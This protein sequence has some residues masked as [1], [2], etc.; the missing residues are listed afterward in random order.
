MLNFT[1]ERYI[2]SLNSAQISYEHWHRY[3]YASQ[4]V[5]NK[6]ILDIASGEGYGSNYLANSAK[7]V[8]GVD[9][10]EEA[11]AFARTNYKR[12][13][14]EFLIGS[15][16]KIPIDRN[17]VFDVIVSFETIEHVN[18]ESQ[19]K[20]L[21]ETIRLLK[22]D[23]LFIVSTPNKLKYTDNN[24]NYKNDYHI[25]EFYI[26]EFETFLGKY[27]SNIVLIGQKVGIGS[28]IWNM[29]SKKNKNIDF[30]LKYEDNKFIPVEETEDPLYVIAICSNSDLNMKDILYSNLIDISEMLK[31]EYDVMLQESHNRYVNLQEQYLGSVNNFE[32][33][34]KKLMEMS[35]WAATLKKQADE[36]SDWAKKLNREVVAKDEELM[37]M[38]D[39]ATT[40]KQEVDGKNSIINNLKNQIDAIY[41]SNIW[42]FGNKLKT[43]AYKT[44]VIYL[45]RI[46]IIIKRYGIKEL[47]KRIKNKFTY[48]FGI[49]RFIILNNKISIPVYIKSQSK[50]KMTE[51]PKKNGQINYNIDR[52][53]FNEENQELTLRGWAYIINKNKVKSTIKLL[54]VSH[55]Q[56][57]I[58]YT[59]P[60]KRSDV[61]LYFNN[62]NLDDSGF[63]IEIDLKGIE[64]GEYKVGILIQ[65]YSIF[66]Q[67]LQ[68]IK[69]DKSVSARFS[70]LKPI[71]NNYK[72]CLC[73]YEEFLSKRNM[74]FMNTSNY[75]ILFFSIIDWDTRYQRP[76]HIASGL[77]EMNHR[78][79]YISA[80]LREIGTYSFRKIKENIYEITLPYYK[81]N[82]IYSEEIKKDITR[83]Y[84]TMDSLFNDF[85][86]KESIAFVEFPMW[87]HIVK[88]IKEKYDVKVVFDLLDEFSG[89]SNVHKNIKNYEEKM[90]YL[91]DLCIVTSKKILNNINS[92]TDRYQIIPNATEFE[93]FN[94]L[95]VSKDKYLMVYDDRFSGRW[96]INW[97]DQDNCFISASFIVFR[98]D[99]IRKNYIS[100]IIQEDI[101]EK[102]KTGILYLVSNDENPLLLHSFKL[103][104]FKPGNN[105]SEKNNKPIEILSEEFNT[106][107]S[108]TV[109]KPE[110]RIINHDY[111]K[112]QIEIEFEMGYG[113]RDIINVKKPIIG[114][115]GAIA[116]WFDTDIIDYIAKTKPEWNIVLIGLTLGS[117]TD[118]LK[119]Y[120]N[121]F[122]LGEKPYEE[123]T[124]Y[125]YWFD[126]CLIPFKLC[127]LILSTNPVKFFEYLSSGK[128][129]VSSDLPELRPYQ[130]LFYMAKTKEQF[131][132]K[133]EMA[134]KEDDKEIIDRRIEFARNND[135]EHRIADILSYIQNIFPKVSI[136]IISYNN[137]EIT[138][139]CIDSILEKTAYPNYEIIIVD[140]NSNQETKEFLR[141]F[142]D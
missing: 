3:L 75:D 96:Q 121:V 127:D 34:H 46:L 113:R 33:E 29:N 98:I 37:K 5:H 87:Y 22:K 93:Y 130:E 71:Q 45:L 35:D 111:Q 13:N 49:R 97:Y 65:K 119:V 135:W 15:V 133:I 7:E 9:I 131:V 17:Y 2:S 129:V 58:F 138:E 43:L 107:I 19:E 67:I 64:K 117:D 50:F 73:S 24:E 74:T 76:Q 10:S 104:G 105:I 142:I 109:S 83:L 116:E 47:F 112:Y 53:L 56:S 8:V 82:W 77:A 100:P 84:D 123:L 110:K 16:D 26:E 36:V 69:N 18:Q 102:A 81:L 38:S 118:R 61:A 88:Y 137:K 79:F 80:T 44:G 101:P 14:L 48:K 51:L 27:F 86:I 23:G 136:I 141:L 54:L 59:T 85:S 68:K 4:Y 62:K 52:F 122:M 106:P 60:E 11:V 6:K 120:P 103:L 114:Y 30:Y 91:S 125:L 124:E 94:N 115:Y 41:T 78:V 42:R 55:K 57:Y 134:L 139:M 108:V 40:L 95:P 66:D 92:K 126:V 70:P 31:K 1:G 28:H 140:N 63:K 132:E 25:K 89:F 128:P 12:S 39:W 72:S 99:K 32:L 20:F 21:N 90:I